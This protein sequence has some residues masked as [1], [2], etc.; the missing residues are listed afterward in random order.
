V[1]WVFLILLA[2]CVVFVFCLS[3][4]FVLCTHYCQFF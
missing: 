3:L 1:G 2:S 4:F